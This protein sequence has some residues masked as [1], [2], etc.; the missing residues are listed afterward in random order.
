MGTRGR[1]ACVFDQAYD[2]GQQ[3]ARASI[4][5]RRPAVRLAGLDAPGFIL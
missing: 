4:P 2:L 3:K 1:E 5:S